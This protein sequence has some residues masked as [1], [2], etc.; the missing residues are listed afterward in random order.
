MM[1]LEQITEGICDVGWKYLDNEMISTIH[2]VP[3]KWTSLMRR[4]AMAC[5]YV[6]REARGDV[7]VEDDESSKEDDDTEPDDEDESRLD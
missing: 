7:P 3:P 1:H 6:R 4:I 2:S 5:E